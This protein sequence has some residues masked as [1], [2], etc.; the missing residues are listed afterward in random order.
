MKRPSPFQVD[1]VRVR[2]HSGPRKDGRW[3]WRADKPDGHDHRIPVWSGWATR[4][5]AGEI[6]RGILG[7]SQ[8]STGELVTVRDLVECWV[9]SQE[10][11]SDVSERTAQSCKEAGIRLLAH[12][13]AD[14]QLLVLGRKQIEGHRDTA[15]RS[16]CAGSTVRRDLKYLRQAWRWALDSNELPGVRLLPTV[17]V[18]RVKP[19]YTRYTPSIEDVVALLEGVSPAVRRGLVLL[20]STGCRISEITSL[21]WSGVPLDASKIRVEGKTGERVVELHSVVAAE[22]RR[23]DRLHRDRYV[24]GVTGQTIRAA[25]AE[26]SEEL[27]IPR[28]S[29]NGLRRHVVDA[30]YRT[31]RI[32]AAASLLGHSAATALAIYRQVSS[33]DRA[34][35]MEGAALGTVLTLSRLSSNHPETAAMKAAGEYSQGEATPPGKGRG[36]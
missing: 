5:E 24:V 19:V 11:R 35:A 29:P 1:H 16:R 27:G 6:V 23:W 20:A 26:R 8:E 21:R 7:E 10:A 14:V 18:E 28:V 30:L 25:L 36:R 13:L 4:D 15:L 22:V 34:A 9:A 33:A 32:D 31:G 2:V 12:G 17:K 3:R